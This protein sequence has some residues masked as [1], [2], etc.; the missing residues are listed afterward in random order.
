MAVWLQVIGGSDRVDSERRCILPC[1]EKC[2]RRHL[3]YIE[4][5]SQIKAFCGL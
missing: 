4:I 2:Y 3:Q 5:C 1:R